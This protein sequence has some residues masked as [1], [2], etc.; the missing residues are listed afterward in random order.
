MQYKDVRDNPYLPF[1]N[2]KTDEFAQKEQ[3]VQK[4]KKLEDLTVPIEW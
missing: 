1:E 2:G 3:S 4:E